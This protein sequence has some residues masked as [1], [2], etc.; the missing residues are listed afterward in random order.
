MMKLSDEPN[1]H[2][3][4]WPFHAEIALFHPFPSALAGLQVVVSGP[5][6]FVL[7]VAQLLTEMGVPS[8]AVVFLD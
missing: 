5:G 4:T 1:I 2:G 3:K 7:N 8:D 6:E